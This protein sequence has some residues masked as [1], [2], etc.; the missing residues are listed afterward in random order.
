M[1]CHYRQQVVETGMAASM[2]DD[3]TCKVFVFVRRNVSRP[4]PNDN[5]R[6]DC[7]PEGAWMQRGSEE[8]TLP[9]YFPCHMV[10]CHDKFN[11]SIPWTL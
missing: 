6:A 9:A 11:H 7:I 8:S 1:D 4:V 3:E 10:S 2:R 5:T